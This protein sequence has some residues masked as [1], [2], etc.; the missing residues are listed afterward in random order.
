MGSWDIVDNA[1]GLEDD[2]LLL[3]R[4]HERWEVHV[5]PRLLMSSDQF[6]SEQALAELAI[7]RVPGAKR[8]LVGGLGLGFTARAALDLLPADAEVVIA[9]ASPALVRWNRTHVADVAGRPLDD[10]RASLAM[11]DV[12]EHIAASEGAYDALLLDVDNGPAVLTHEGNDR[13][14]DDEGI[15]ACMRAL[16]PEGVLAV[17]SAYPNDEF[18]DRL[19]ANGLEAE[20]V[21]APAGGHADYDHVIF[22]ARRVPRA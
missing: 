15:R 21:S 18:V 3:V 20:A 14:Y 9:E 8:V 13:L 7:R 2:D 19:R 10:P 1:V 16:R 12:V 17:W 11:G 5:G 6:L 22:L 4:T